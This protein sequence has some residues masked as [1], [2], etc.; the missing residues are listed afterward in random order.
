[1]AKKS[2]SKKNVTP[3]NHEEAHV[4]MIVEK[5]EYDGSKT[6]V[7]EKGVVQENENNPINTIQEGKAIVGLSKGLTINLQNYESARINCWISK[8]TN[9]DEV[10]IMD[11]LVQISG[12]IDEQLQFEVDEIMDGRESN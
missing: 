6:I 12:M 9:D 3:K 8:V 7:K 11:T 1:M 5:R 2:P 4:D 10:S